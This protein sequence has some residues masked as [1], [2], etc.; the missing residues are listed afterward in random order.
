MTQTQQWMLGDFLKDASAQES[1]NLTGGKSL[2]GGLLRGGLFGGKGG[3][4]ASLMRGAK[5]T[6]TI[7]SAFTPQRPFSVAPLSRTMRLMQLR[8]PVDN[9]RTPALQQLTMRSGRMPAPV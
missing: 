3:I 8:K 9:F 5:A 4:P 7:G 1:A 2:G 6:K